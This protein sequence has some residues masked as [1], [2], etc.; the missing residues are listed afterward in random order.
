MLRC[1]YCLIDQIEPGSLEIDPEAAA[2]AVT[3]VG[4][5]AACPTH[6][7]EGMVAEVERLASKTYTPSGVEKIMSV[8]RGKR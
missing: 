8:V 6:M 5:F 1:A 7:V 3:V 4:G 2:E